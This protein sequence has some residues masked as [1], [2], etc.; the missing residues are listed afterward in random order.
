V[1]EREIDE[2]AFDIVA[3]RSPGFDRRLFSSVTKINSEL[4]LRRLIPSFPILLCRVMY[5][6]ELPLTAGPSCR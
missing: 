5:L 6:I 1:A 3:T 2:R 4:D